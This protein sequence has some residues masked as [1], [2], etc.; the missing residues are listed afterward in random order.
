MSGGDDG[1]D[2]DGDDDGDGTCL[3]VCPPS[4]RR[5]PPQSP[6]LRLCVQSDHLDND[7]D[8]GDDEIDGDGMV[9]EYSNDKPLT[10]SVVCSALGGWVE[11]WQT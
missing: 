3:E 6:S 9:I 8:D 7:N 1:D 4:N 5:V 2:D 10:A 11:S